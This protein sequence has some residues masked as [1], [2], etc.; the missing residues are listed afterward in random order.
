MNAIDLSLG[1]QVAVLDKRVADLPDKFAPEAGFAAFVHSKSGA[2]VPE[3][4]GRLDAARLKDAPYL[5]ACGYRLFLGSIK[6]KSD[7]DAWKAGLK[8]LQRRDPFAADRQTFFFRPL[9]LLGLSLG[10]SCLYPVGATEQSW[11]VNHLES[12]EGKAAYSGPDAWGMMAFS[13]ASHILKP[14]SVIQL[15]PYQFP[16]LDAATHALL[17]WLTMMFPN[18]VD[19]SGWD[20]QVNGDQLLS[21]ALTENWEDLHAGKAVV[22]SAAIRLL[23]GK[24]IELRHRPTDFLKSILAGVPAGL[25]RW[26]YDSDPEGVQWPILEEKHFQDLLWLVLRPVFPDIV[27]EEALPKFGFKQSTPDFAI[28][29][30][31]TLIEVKFIFKRSDYKVRFEEIEKDVIEYFHA[32]QEFKN[33]VVVVYDNVPCPELQGQF[34]KDLLRIKGIADVVVIARPGKFAAPVPRRATKGRT[35]RAPAGQLK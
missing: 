30:L 6:E 22:V 16:A 24:S 1:S 3:T 34:C 19:A 8:D 9:E 25:S 20:S 33:L 5:S 27:D 18:L 31:A 21:R 14:A 23:I 15:K 11:I 35:N 17:A 29:S 13:L 7:I 26:R 28:P 10:I 12:D 32:S 4:V 2:S